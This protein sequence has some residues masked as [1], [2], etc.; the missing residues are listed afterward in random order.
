MPQFFI[1]REN[2]FGDMVSITGE[3]FHHLKNVRRVK[4]GDAIVAR[5][6]EGTCYDVRVERIGADSIDCFV[7]N[8]FNPSHSGLRIKLYLALLK[9]G[10]FEHVLQ[11]SVEVGIFSIIPVLT[12]RTI[13]RIGDK[14]EAKCS[15]W[16]KI[17]HAASKQ[18]MR[19]FI[20]EFFCPMNFSDVVNSEQGKATRILAHPAGELSFREYAQNSPK[21]EEVELLIGSEGGFS[22]REIKLAKSRGWEV[23][24]FGNNQLRAETAGAIIPSIVLY[25]WG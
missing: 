14:L 9:R 4:I 12:E 5:D 19:D 3:N 1:E 11:K 7:I 24:N 25:E 22:G 10:S 17:V 6:G 8:S 13:P 23:L 21:P 18:S 15:R 2:V 16:E 20:P